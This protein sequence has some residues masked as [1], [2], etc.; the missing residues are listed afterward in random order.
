[1]P[2]FSRQTTVSLK[3]RHSEKLERIRKF[4]NKFNLS[5]LVQQAIE[6]YDEFKPI[7]D[8]LPEGYSIVTNLVRTHRQEY[9][10]GDTVNTTTYT[11][12]RR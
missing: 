11:T 6:D 9:Q 3:S 5:A 4:D 7:R 10:N 2:R 12:L 1:M 8:M